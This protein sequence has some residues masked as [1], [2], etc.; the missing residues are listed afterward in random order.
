MTNA[1]QYEYDIFVSYAHVDDDP[2]AGASK[3]W[4]TTFVSS[5]KIRLAQKLGRYDAYSLWM[6]HELSGSEPITPTLLEKVRKAATLV[7]VLSPGYVASK[8]CQRER[9]TFLSLVQER[10]GGRVFIVEREM[11]DDSERPDEFK[12]LKGFRFWVQDREGK[13]PRILGSPRPDPADQEYY[14]LIDDLSQEIV[15]E[16]RRLRG[17]TA[18]PAKT[19]LAAS[20][21]QPLSFSSQQPTVYLAQVT[22][23]LELE[24]N[25]IKRYLD[26]A[27]VRVVP[28]IW[29]SQEPTAF[30]Q[31]AERDL[32]QAQLFVQLLSGTAGKKPIDVPQGYPRFQLDLAI[33]AGKP[34]LQWRSPSLDVAAV[35][36]DE[37]RALLEAVTVRAESI[38]DFKRELRRRLFEQP[39][40]QVQK[41]TNTF[42]FVDMESSDRPL[43]EQI[44]DILDRQGAEFVL[45]IYSNDPAEGSVPKVLL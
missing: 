25:H 43:A 45:P 35:E 23:D 39:Q 3:G 11:V 22:D 42:V 28:A 8:W 37:H 38:E 7:V 27:E 29:Y 20:A 34:I 15:L 21:E 31:A 12:D 4:V 10:G 24:R 9:D 2:L 36:D 16:L 14:N 13:A 33:A 40:P 17:M 26:Q 1:P 6:D 19:P 44:C 41:R 32:A 5:L 18:Q 30:R